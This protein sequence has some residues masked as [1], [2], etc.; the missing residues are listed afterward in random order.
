MQIERELSLPAAVKR[1]RPPGGELANGRRCTKIGQTRPQLLRTSG[2]EP[3]RLEAF[4]F[5]ELLQVIIREEYNQGSRLGNNDSPLWCI[6]SQDEDLDQALFCGMLRMSSR[7]QVLERKPKN[8]T[9]GSR[10]ILKTDTLTPQDLFYTPR[11]FVVPLFQ[12]PYVWTCSGQWEPLWE[13]VVRIAE[14]LLEDPQAKVEPHFLGAVVLQEVSGG[15][16]KL[17]QRIVIDGQQRITTLQLL[18]DAVQ[19]EF[20]VAGAVD[21]ATMTRRLVLNEKVYCK[22]PGDEFKICPT[23]KDRPAFNAVMGAEPPVAY[24]ALLPKGALLIEA[25]R[26]FAQQAQ[27][28]LLEGPIAERAGALDRALREL[29]QIVV[30]DLGIDE[31]A[32]E[33][34]ETLNARGT[35]LTAADLI[36]N[37]VFQRVREEGADDEALYFKYWADFETPFWELE[38]RSGRVMQPRVSQFLTHWL[39]AKTGE[40]I[41]AREVFTRF[42]RFARQSK[43][44]M[45][46]LL[47]E[48]HQCAQVYAS[49]VMD[50]EKQHGPM[51]RRSL[52][53]Y[54]TATLESDTVRP[55]VL[56]LLD[57]QL[58]KVP[59]PQLEKAFAVLESWLVRRMLV[60]AT[61]KSYNKIVPE[62]IR[63]VRNLERSTLGDAIEGFLAKQ[64]GDSR[65]WPDDAELREQLPMLP[66]YRRIGRGRLRMVLEAL[67]DRRRG[68]TN[69]QD[70][71]GGQRADR[72][73]WE[74]EHV[75]P[76][77]WHKH[78][79][80]PEDERQRDLRIHTLGNL[81]LLT[82]RLNVRVSNGPWVGD[83]GK[84]H[85]LR[86]HDSIFMNRDLREALKWSDLA[87]EQRTAQLVELTLEVWPTPK[88]HRVAIVRTPRTPRKHPG[89]IDLL[90]AGK[91]HAGMALHGKS[92]S[93]SQRKA[94]LLPDGRLDVDGSIHA[95]LSA[96]AS[97]IAGNSQNGW[98][99]FTATP[100]TRKPLIHMWRD[101][102]DSI[103]NT[104][105][106][107]PDESDDEPS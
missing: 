38:V 7:S 88:G 68:F 80:A 4:V 41:V 50:S 74:I 97:A 98:Y 105:G 47:Q 65:Y 2:A 62:L 83:G 14:Q 51:D 1:V 81:T 13:D 106:N 53:G 70:G 45:P 84:Q 79:P 107:S 11:R 31:N 59:T 61:T 95:S 101:Y 34:F 39:V 73:A 54:R 85:A 76:Q 29:L 96:A 87:I 86:E 18:M 93:F 71:L 25:H 19:A 16:G 15:T 94:I 17:Q 42:K 67:D 20:A 64:T 37:F 22:A 6:V 66:I 36:K 58:S 52:F 9:F 99:F 12:R 44:S 8:H 43:K 104:D 102:V 49:F 82:K 60:R 3:L 75:M 56:L 72:G 100:T 26:Y 32:Q 5:T 35:P 89:L 24:D 69:T 23:N 10:R 46:D 21:Q 91:L 103:A 57:P 27:E 77:E 92:K 63:H 78:W 30:I 90:D 55:L 28:W 48:I 33:I 40:E